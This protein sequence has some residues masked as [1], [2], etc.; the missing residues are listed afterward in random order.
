MRGGGRAL[1]GERSRH[2]RRRS[3]RNS[4][5]SVS[6]WMESFPSFHGKSSVVHA[7][8]RDCCRARREKE[9]GDTARRCE[10]WD[11]G[12]LIAPAGKSGGGLA[13]SVAHVGHRDPG[14]TEIVS[15]AGVSAH[16]LKT[17]S[18]SQGLEYVARGSQFPSA[19]AAAPKGKGQ[20]LPGVGV[21]HWE[22]GEADIVLAGSTGDCPGPA[23]ACPYSTCYLE[24]LTAKQASAPACPL[25]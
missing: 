7:C 19:A 23:V 3:R 4:S 20:E 6:C 17:K 13:C 10:M 21:K 24:G 25:A 14:P 18:Q 8:M 22:T 15:N 5:L 2:A 9:A 1:G 12:E 16:T 11:A